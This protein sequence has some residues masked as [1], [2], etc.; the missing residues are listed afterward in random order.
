MKI[1]LRA[2]LARYELRSPGTP[3]V[4]RRRG[5][6]FSPSDGCRVI[7]GERRAGAPHGHASAPQSAPA[8]V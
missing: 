4:T 2:V 6:T 3:E 8:L 1:V 7:L 5:I